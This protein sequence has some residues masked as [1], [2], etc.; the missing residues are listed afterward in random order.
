V[1]C[2]QRVRLI[3]RPIPLPNQVQVFGSCFVC[4][5][6]MESQRHTHARRFDAFL[7]FW[8]PPA[9]RLTRGICVSCASAAS[10]SDDLARRLA[11]W[12][13]P[14]SCQGV[15]LR[16]CFVESTSTLQM[17][18]VTGNGTAENGPVTTSQSSCFSP[19]RWLGQCCFTGSSAK[20]VFTVHTCVALNHGLSGATS[21]LPF[22]DICL[23]RL[24]IAYLS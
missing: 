13:S 4:C 3:W 19:E 12:V 14:R 7:V 16:F 11:F 20:L 18:M 10:K 24:F 6:P 5:R 15:S 17:P 8:C 2:V 1:N 9:F 21:W 22:V 23:V